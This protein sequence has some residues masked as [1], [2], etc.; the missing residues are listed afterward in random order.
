MVSHVFRRRLLDEK[1][2]ITWVT[3]L[4]LL[5]AASAV[6]LAWVWGPIYIVHYEVKQVVRDY[7]NQ[8]VKEKGDAQLVERMLHKFRTLDYEW[9]INELGKQV[10]VPVINLEPRDVLWERSDDPSPQLHVAFEYVRQV[11]YPFLDVTTEV[12]MPVDITADISLPDW[13]PAR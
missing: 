2:K 3:L 8:A 4:F 7:C 11:R 9:T 5:G 12:R 13:G 6:Y 10:K 1:G